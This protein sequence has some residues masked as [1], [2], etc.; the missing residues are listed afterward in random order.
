MPSKHSLT[1]PAHGLGDGLHHAPDHAPFTGRLVQ[2]HHDVV[3]GLLHQLGCFGD[4]IV[5]VGGLE[6]TVS[7]LTF[8][9]HVLLGVARRKFISLTTASECPYSWWVH[10][11]SI[12]DTSP[13]CIL[14]AVQ[15]C[16]TL[17]S[18]NSSHFMMLR[19]R[20]CAVKRFKKKGVRIRIINKIR[21]PGK[22]KL[23]L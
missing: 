7:W 17:F 16:A 12:E 9:W 8:L 6:G 20:S 1:H 11:V 19:L 21:N 23:F 5:G 22:I 4:G 18:N 10:S 2:S 3:H 13:D 14:A 15:T